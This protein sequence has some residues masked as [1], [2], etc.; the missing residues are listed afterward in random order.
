M[1]PLPA[2]AIWDVFGSM[3]RGSATVTSSF[4]VAELTDLG[5]RAEMVGGDV[6]PRHARDRGPGGRRAGHGRIEQQAGRPG[7][8]AGAGRG[9]AAGVRHG[10]NHSQGGGGHA[11][12][13]HAN[14]R[15][16]PPRPR[17]AR[18][19][20]GRVDGRPGHRVR[21]VVEGRG[22]LLRRRHDR[23]ARSILLIRETAPSVTGRTAGPRTRGTGGMASSGASCKTVRSRRRARWV[24]DFTVPGVHPSTA[25][26]S[27]IDRSSQN[28]RTRT[29]RC[30]AGQQ[31]ACAQ[32]RLPVQHGGRVVTG[33]PARQPG[34]VGDQGLRPPAPPGPPPVP[35]EVHQDGSGIPVRVLPRRRPPAGQPQQCYLDQVLG[36]LVVPGQQQGEAEQPPTVAGEIPGFELRLI[37]GRQRG[38][39]SV[40]LAPGW[41]ASAAAPVVNSPAGSERWPR[42]GLERLRTF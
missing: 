2:A 10:D 32:Q 4:P 34:R 11:C 36:V 28:R 19:D 22:Q 41:T 14:R 1:R 29:A 3:V 39:L 6:V 21:L 25:A 20:P 38:T 24:W 13:G 42:P 9:S 23:S 30:A 8:G 27:S 35:G 12:R 7:R 33:A 26:V 17:P 40:G 15:A 18:E 16:A 5:D 37:P 31:P